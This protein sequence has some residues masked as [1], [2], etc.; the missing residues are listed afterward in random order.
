MTVQKSTALTSVTGR[1]QQQSAGV[2]NLPAG[3]PPSP[4][5]RMRTGLSSST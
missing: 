2:R 5:R 1:A 4:S 3:R